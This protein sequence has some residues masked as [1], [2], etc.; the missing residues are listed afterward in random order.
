MVHLRGMV[1]E[2]WYMVQESK[3]WYDY[4]IMVSSG[5]AAYSLNRKIAWP[6]PNYFP[7]RNFDK[8]KL[9]LASDQSLSRTL[10]TKIIQQD[11]DQFPIKKFV[12]KVIR[13][14]PNQSPTREFVKKSKPTSVHL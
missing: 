13:L 4:I 1:H 6:T 10:S 5:N 9:E 12:K 3:L 2:G 7:T 11:P 8:T 14:A